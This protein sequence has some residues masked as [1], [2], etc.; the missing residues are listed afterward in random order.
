V[1]VVSKL[2]LHYN[3]PAA[4]EEAMMGSSTVIPSGVILQKRRSALQTVFDLILHR[5]PIAG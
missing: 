1:E 2:L 3:K 5:E 4:Y